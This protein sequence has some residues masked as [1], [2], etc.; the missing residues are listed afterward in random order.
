MTSRRQSGTGEPGSASPPQWRQRVSIIGRM[1]LRLRGDVVV[2]YELTVAVAGVE[3]VGVDLVVIH[4]DVGDGCQGN[5]APE[6]ADRVVRVEEV[7]V[8]PPYVS[9]QGAVVNV[10]YALRVVQGACTAVRGY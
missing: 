1:S 10:G 8:P 9:S 2:P 7:Q 6:H 3:V 4:G 5:R